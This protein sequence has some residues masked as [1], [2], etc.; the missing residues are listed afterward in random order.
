MAI[1]L[2]RIFTG[3]N[4]VLK[5]EGHFHGWHDQVVH[6]VN[7]P[8]EAPVPGTVRGVMSMTVL[9]PPNDIKAVEKILREDDDIACVIIEPTGGGFG[10]IPT[11][12]DFLKSLR[13]VATEMV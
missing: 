13:E 6:G 7:P 9:C 4:K 12:G 3:K 2:S 10:A 8:Y 5:F 1:R 11:G